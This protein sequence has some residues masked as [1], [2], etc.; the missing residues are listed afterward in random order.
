MYIYIYIYRERE[1]MIGVFPC[2][3]QVLGKL[4][5]LF[6]YVTATEDVALPTGIALHCLP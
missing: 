5:V 2:V 1:I 4:A 3:V 6:L